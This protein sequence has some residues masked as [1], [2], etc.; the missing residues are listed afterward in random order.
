MYAENG[1]RII[2]FPS[3][4]FSTTFTWYEFT[5]E[6]SIKEFANEAGAEFPILGK[7]Q[8]SGKSAHPL[9]KWLQKES[10]K[11]IDHNFGKFLL[12]GNGKIIQYLNSETPVWAFMSDIYVLL[13]DP[14]SDEL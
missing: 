4:S 8:L 12:D 2:A 6:S 9:F 3:D 14:I 11:T 10:G 13:S 1:L 5:F 7:V